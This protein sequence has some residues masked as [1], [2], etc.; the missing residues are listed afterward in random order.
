VADIDQAMSL[1]IG[2]PEAAERLMDKFWPGPLTLV[3]PRHP[4]FVADLGN[5]DITVG[6][7]CPA[8]VVARL[9]CDEFGPVAITTANVSGE[10]PAT[11]A[12]QIVET[13]GREVEVIL[14]GGVC[15]SPPATVVDCTGTDPK[16]LREGAI[17]WT[18]ITS[19]LR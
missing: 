16:L 11:T 8:K 14:D 3:L 5:D 2:V 12:Q 19:V 15:D 13:F 6:I 1:A 4:D 17:A 18:D 10:Q 9:L 7:R